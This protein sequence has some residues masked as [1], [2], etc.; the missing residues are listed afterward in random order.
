M[1]QPRPAEVLR[2]RRG[3]DVPPHSRLRYW[4]HPRLLLL[5]CA[6]IR[7]NKRPWLI[8]HESLVNTVPREDQ[9]LLPSLSHV[10]R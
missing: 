7:I 4:L 2:Y 9:L 8:G 1:A 5:L 3:L 6:K 10:R